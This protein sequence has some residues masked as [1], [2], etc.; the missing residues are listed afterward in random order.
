M[1]EAVDQVVVDHADRL[2]VR[3]DDGRA[4]E[5]ETALLEIFAEGVGRL[6]S[7]RNIP[8]G[9]PTI[10]DGPP[11]DEAPL[12]RVEASEL[13]L[14]PEKRAR[15]AH[16]RGD[17]ATVAHDARIAEQRGDLAL[18]VAR[19]LRRIEPIEGATVGV[20]LAQDGDPAQTGLRS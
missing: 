6:G 3:I 4:D 9:T 5:V 2:H 20:A 15:V 12:V 1:A 19:H 8:D 16:C 18:A 13:L 17:L 7:R 14:H 10:L 11:V